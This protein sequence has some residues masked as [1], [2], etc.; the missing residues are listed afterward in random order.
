[1]F[2]IMAPGQGSQAPGMLAG[3]LRDPAH[4]ER[5]RAWSEAADCDLVHLGTRASA[6]E[7]ARTENT[8]P[9]LVAAG[10][11]AHPELAGTGQADVAVGHSVGELTAAAYAGVLGPVDAVRLAAVRGRAMAAACAEAPT[12]MAAVVGG[13][14][15]EVLARISELGL[16]AA[17]FNGPGQIVAAGLTER[18]DE[19]A[20][21]PPGST[22]VKRLPVAGAFHTPFMESARQTVAAAAAAIPF[23]PPRGLLLSNA[24]G[25]AVADPELIR[26][27]L[28]DQVVRPVRWDR[29][30]ASLVRL[31]PGV[32]VSLPP[33]RTLANLLKRQHPG[34]GVV[35]VNSA[36]DIG[37]ALARIDAAAGKGDPARAGA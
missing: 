36:R 26:Q 14:A 27:R 29:C 3:W 37:K 22:T 25:E 9:L 31:A 35:P 6:A 34:L 21:T 33:A 13:D 17:T 18:L 5:A 23:A 8:Q 30:L 1:M 19:L 10:L 7:I 32:T 15:S 20:A 16:T 4:A 12:S 11:L 2:A 24:D 28:V